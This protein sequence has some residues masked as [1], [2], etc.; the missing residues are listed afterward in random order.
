[1][2]LEDI[3]IFFLNTTTFTL[4]LTNMDDI[5]KI[6]LLAVSIG[7]TAQRWYLMNKDEKDK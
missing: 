1:M 7:Y 6:I 2:S 4:S 3:R 5:L